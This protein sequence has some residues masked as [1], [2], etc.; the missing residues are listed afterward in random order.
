MAD[1]AGPAEMEIY[2]YLGPGGLLAVRICSHVNAYR[3]SQWLKNQR[4]EGSLALSAE[5][6]CMTVHVVVVPQ[7]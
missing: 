4:T 5:T 7:D 1:T 2:N 6:V 3:N